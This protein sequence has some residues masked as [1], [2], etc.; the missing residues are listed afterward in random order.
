MRIQALLFTTAL[1]LAGAA[2]AAHH[3]AGEAKSDTAEIAEPTATRNPALT[4]PSLA[5][6]TAP[7]QFK[8]EFDTTQGKFVVK[9][10]RSWSPNGADRFYN[11]ADIGYFEDI[12]FFRVIPNFMAQFGIHGDPDVSRAWR[13]ASIQDDPVVQSNKRGYITYAKTGR[14][15]SRTVQ[16]FINFKDNGN[17]DRMGFAPFGEV[18][19]GMDVVDA[20]YKVGEGRPRGPGPGQQAIQARGNAYLKKDFPKLDYIKSAKIVE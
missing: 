1:L 12:A 18:V 2:P 8:V 20:I 6:K 4:D 17:L 19:E 10:T 15:N 13:G 3:E 14:P 5:N 11:L 9:V 16:L 7:D